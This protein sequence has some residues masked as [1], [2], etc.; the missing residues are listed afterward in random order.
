MASNFT[1]RRLYL[2]TR[3]GAILASVL[4]V[5][6]FSER[7]STR[8]SEGLAGHN[9]EQM[10]PG[11]NRLETD[12]KKHPHHYQLP[13]VPSHGPDG[14]QKNSGHSHIPAEVVVFSFLGNP[15]FWFS[16][17]FLRG[18]MAS[19]IDNSKRGKTQKSMEE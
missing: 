6:I 1:W 11:S 18:W 19:N 12:Q 17:K 4:L 9:I 13:C 7:R 14:E 10:P 5:A 3:A 8:S 15:R 16:G 2:V